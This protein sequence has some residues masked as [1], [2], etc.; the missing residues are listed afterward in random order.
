MKLL[1]LQGN[2]ECIQG[3]ILISQKHKNYAHENEE[4]SSQDNRKKYLK[5]VNE[6]SLI[7]K[8]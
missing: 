6:T 8:E 1:F 7:Q 4:R 2:K 5:E 3:E